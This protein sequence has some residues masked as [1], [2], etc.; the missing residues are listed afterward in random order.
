[1]IQKTKN[2]LY[3]L[4]I[5]CVYML[6]SP[7]LAGPLVLPDLP[8]QAS[9]VEPNVMLLMDTSQSM[10]TIVPS[11]D[12]LDFK[13]NGGVT[14][15]EIKYYGLW[16][17]F[18]KQWMT[19]NEVSDKHVWKSDMLRH[20]S[21]CS[22]GYVSF[23][24]K[25]NNNYIYK[26][27]KLPALP[28]NDEKD[29]VY[30]QEYLRYLANN[31]GG[32]NNK[33]YTNII[34]KKT[35]MRVAKDVAI[36]LVKDNDKIRFG[37]SS[38]YLNDHSKKGGA[39]VVHCCG[40][41]CGNNDI[42]KS[43]NSL[44]ATVPGTPLASAYYELT[45]YFRGLKSHTKSNVNHN[46]PIQYRCQESFVLVLTDG[47][48]ETDAKNLSRNSVKY[49]DPDV[50]NNTS[51]PDWDGLSTSIKNNVIP[52]FSDGK[53][54]TD[55]S[56]EGPQDNLFLDDMVKFGYD[57]DLV[58]SGVDLAGVSFN[59]KGFETQRLKAYTVGFAL[60]HQML[61]DAAHYGSGDYLTADN[62]ENLKAVMQGYV[63][64]IVHRIGTKSG[65]GVTSGEINSGS[66]VIQTRFN[67]KNWSG[68]MR[69]YK[70]HTDVT[71]DNYGTIDNSNSSYDDGALV[72]V[73]DEMPDW[74][75]R[76]LFSSNGNKGVR[77]VWGQLSKGQK[78]LLKSEP[79]LLDY[80]KGKGAVAIKSSNKKLD[81]RVRD[82]VLADIVHSKPVY[83][84]SPSQRYPESIENDSYASFKKRYENRVPI[85]YVG[86]NGGMLHA[87]NTVDGKEE[88]AFVPADII[89]NLHYMSD[90]E[91]V[92]R[93]YVDATPSVNDAYINN[94][95]G[96]FLV[97]GLRKGGQSIFALDVT[98]AGNLDNNDN[99][100]KQLFLW[101][102]SDDDDPDMG[103]SYGQPSIVKM[104]DGKWYAV[105]GNGYNS[106]EK[107]KSF[108]STG[109]AVVFIVDLETGKKVAKLS[110]KVG[111]KEDP[112][113][114]GRPNGIAEITM[115][116]Q[117]S[118][119]IADYIYAGDLFGNIWKF[120]ITG[121]TTQ[122]WKLAYKL[123][124]ACSGS[125]K[126]K[127]DR[128][129]VTAPLGIGPHPSKSGLML[130][131][132]TG[133]RL[134]AL[135]DTNTQT[136]E[137]LYG[138]WDSG[139]KI[140]GRNELLQQKIEFQGVVEFDDN[141]VT[142]ASTV[143]HDLRVVSSKPIKPEH[144]GWYLDLVA[145]SN[146]T[147]MGE[148]LLTR[149]K[150]R[151]NRVLFTTQVPDFVDPCMSAD[152]TSWLLDLNASNG[153]RLN[154][155]VFD[156]N[157]DG[158]VDQDDKVKV[159]KDPQ[160]ND[161]VTPD[162]NVQVVTGVNGKQFIVASASGKRISRSV[163]GTLQ[164]TNSAISVGTEILQSSKVDTGIDSHRLYGQ[165]EIGRVS[166][167]Q[168]ERG[169]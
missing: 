27:L 98:E 105:F 115:V 60:E 135:D 55:L 67:P 63:S 7:V 109:D 20:N 82:S 54:P 11:D 144:R 151:N 30:T 157:G 164:S 64:D 39:E 42:G 125:C 35:R 80:I 138:I 77:F 2:N 114:K 16:Y 163:D 152:G 116:D 21:Y 120:D 58:K 136:V 99:D 66:Q 50:N 168:L 134:E 139:S 91:Y 5:F 74:N 26:C 95:W 161:D 167:R 124:T 86:S 121:S 44:E 12:F 89:G 59:D 112:T 132:G 72:S 93:Y 23:R 117:N 73:A 122:S 15:G 57:I 29:G 101:D 107:D 147:S 126:T 146:S 128:Q 65:A 165:T 71:K 148:R 83:V 24:I 62:A 36:S 88:F 28:N 81:Y 22:A 156:H 166:W 75:K 14:A 17:G 37:V 162:A 8:F 158:T 118:D 103:Y 13:E 56:K 110:T 169:Y 79:N 76:I 154:F 123:F 3:K 70:L 49:N 19:L 130:Y 140:N 52:P 153:G 102:F 92:H 53:F 47:N 155:Q 33:D 18:F 160:G 78:K 143:S 32:T 48:P 97:S 61:A 106:T 85:V 113:G 34:P 142:P 111:T 133:K 43:I 46:S 6:A 96:T 131:F 159:E 1:M 69:F 84:A 68:D 41:G 150:Y 137:S 40:G 25:K 9:V 119:H 145:P 31:T 10:A 100:A 90:K 51:F 4:I 129:S 94:K 127:A 141:S 108:S 45:R 87:F 149:A 104:N 38:L